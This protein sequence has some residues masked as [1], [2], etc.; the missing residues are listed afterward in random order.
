[1]R[2]LKLCV[3]A[4]LCTD[5]FLSVDVHED[6]VTIFILYLSFVTLL[7]LVCSVLMP[8]SFLLLLLP[9]LFECL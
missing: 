7:R 3:W 1:M 6:S 4:A 9:T 5:F 8:R 2:G